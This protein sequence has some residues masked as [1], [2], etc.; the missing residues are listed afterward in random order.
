MPPAQISKEEQED[1]S[2][3]GDRLQSA[4]GAGSIEGDA[5]K[6]KLISEYKS[7]QANPTEANKAESPSEPA[8]GQDASKGAVSEESRRQFLKRLSKPRTSTK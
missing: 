2:Q 8:A 5:A 1:L 4:A 7:A 6:N 3:L